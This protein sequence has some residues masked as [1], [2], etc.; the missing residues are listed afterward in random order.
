M[1]LVAPDVRGATAVPVA[2]V[3]PGA[4]VV[5][6]DLDV[7]GATAV[8]R[9]PDVSGGPTVPGATVVPPVCLAIFFLLCVF[10][11]FKNNGTQVY[12]SAAGSWSTR[13]FVD[14]KT[15]PRRYF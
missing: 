12:H 2:P 13:A 7:P 10:I 4:P 15:T 6:G 11:H 14:S 5:L 9:A 1:Y 3:V 8:P